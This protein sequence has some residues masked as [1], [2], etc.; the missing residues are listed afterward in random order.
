ME[1]TIK[2]LFTT[3]DSLSLRDPRLPKLWFEHS[4]LVK[5][6]KGQKKTFFKDSADWY[7]KCKRSI[8]YSNDEDTYWLTLVPP[9]VL[10]V[11]PPVLPLT[12]P[13]KRASSNSCLRG[14]RLCSSSM[15]PETRTVMSKKPHINAASILAANGQYVQYTLFSHKSKLKHCLLLSI[16][17]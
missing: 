13:M 8:K 11:L 12:P 2:G 15:I 6:C 3:S 14:S 16:L 5:A 9:L 17:S 1:N 7:N 10:P 4:L